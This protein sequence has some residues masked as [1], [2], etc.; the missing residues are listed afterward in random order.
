MSRARATRMARATGVSVDAGRA[1]EWVTRK[2]GSRTGRRK[3][4]KE[5]SGR[6]GRTERG[7][8]RKRRES[9][10][11]LPVLGAAAGAAL[12]V[13]HTGTRCLSFLALCC[14]CT[15]PGTGPARAERTGPG[16]RANQR[17]R[18][19]ASQA[20]Q[21]LEEEDGDLRGERVNDRR[22]TG[23]GGGRCFFSIAIALTRTQLGLAGLSV[24]TSHGSDGVAC[25]PCR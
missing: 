15:R 2:G 9:A 21:E 6:K 8:T 3:S 12:W 4:L 20:R 11:V 22:G 25:L 19:L 13:W 23:E 10:V 14:L 17:R 16:A 5:R 18:P 24:T 7:P 1:E